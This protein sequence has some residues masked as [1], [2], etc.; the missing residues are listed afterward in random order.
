[1]IGSNMAQTALMMKLTPNVYLYDPFILALE[2]VAEELNIVD[3]KVQI[4]HSKVM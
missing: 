3:S 1:M 2:G 4:I